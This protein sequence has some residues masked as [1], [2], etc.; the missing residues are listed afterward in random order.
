MGRAEQESTA[1]IKREELV[2]LLD[3]M[4][5]TEQ[6]PITARVR[7][8]DI[9]AEAAKTDEE[10]E[11]EAAQLADEAKAA[12]SI[13]TEPQRLFNDVDWEDILG[14]A[15][16]AMMN[17]IVKTVAPPLPERAKRPSKAPFSH[18]AAL[19]PA[20]PAP[21]RRAKTNSGIT[22]ARGTGAQKAVQVI[23]DV[24]A[25]LETAEQVSKWDAQADRPAFPTL[26]PQVAAEL[27]GEEIA[28]LPMEIRLL[29]PEVSPL[30]FPRIAMTP[31]P[32]DLTIGIHSKPC[33]EL[34]HS[35]RVS[36]PV[37]A[38]GK[39]TPESA[40]TSSWS[41]VWLLTYFLI[42]CFTGFGI[43]YCLSAS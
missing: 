28:M 34:G 17:P 23:A 27:T 15:V 42:A 6:Q 25:K 32:A 3:T 16:S 40:P 13:A 24:R 18:I 14:A 21:M 7:I 19:L 38:T 9:Q 5:P 2:G 30:Q 22:A 10:V 35:I 20:T 31:V 8:S 39:A 26:S 41:T 43:V 33:K 1:R 37:E 29:L 11:R 36:E 12:E 4:N